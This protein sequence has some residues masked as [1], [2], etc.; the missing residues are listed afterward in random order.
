MNF[1]KQEYLEYTVSCVNPDKIDTV[2]EVAADTCICGRA[3][4]PYVQSV[5]CLDMTQ[6]ML[7]IGKNRPN[8][9][10]FTISV[11][12]REMPKHSHFQKTASIS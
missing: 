11:L 10:I 5:T 3:L 6:A 8:S 7:D 2:L 12:F 4:A 1:T 9:K